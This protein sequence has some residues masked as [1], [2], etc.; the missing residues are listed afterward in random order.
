MRKTRAKA[1][2][3]R[4]ILEHTPL[5]GDVEIINECN[6]TLLSLT[7]IDNNVC[8]LDKVLS[9]DLLNR[10]VLGVETAPGFVSFR[11]EGVE[12]AE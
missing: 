7:H 11:L 1:M 6:E 4:E 8:S 5:D 3:L 10:I 12:D 2:T 9:D